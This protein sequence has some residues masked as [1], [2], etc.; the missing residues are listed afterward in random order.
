MKTIIKFSVVFLFVLIFTVP[1]IAAA[2]KWDLDPAHSGIYFGID[3]I[4]STTRGYFEDFTGTV[5]FSPD[6][7]AGSRFDFEVKV[8]SINTGNS[9][10]DGHLNSGDFFD[11]KK[12]PAMTFNSTAVEHVK[13]DQYMVKGTMTVKDVSKTVSVPFTFMGTKTHPFDKK[14]EVA[15]F[16]ARMTIDRLA[17]H[18]GGGKFYDM[19]VVGQNVDVLITLEVTRKK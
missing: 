18:V 5:M 11:S 10:R 15:G 12:Y 14:S 4:Y 8:N 13:D 17:Y 9:K 3:H 19:G 1:A 6:D 16:E 7:L 2:P